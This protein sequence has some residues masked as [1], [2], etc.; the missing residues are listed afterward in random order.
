MARRN[1]L[2]EDLTE[3][4][5]LD[6]AAGN[7]RVLK[8]ITDADPRVRLH[9]LLYSK[10]E[11]RQQIEEMGV[12]V[13][14]ESQIARARKHAESQVTPLLKRIDELEKKIGDGQ[15][16]REASDFDASLKRFAN[17]FPITKPT[18]MRTADTTSGRSQE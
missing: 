9:E 7:P 17:E 5:I 16:A 18:S 6:L 3:Q 2:P 14:P 10:P 15:T 4:D 8:A 11:F 13:A 1:D 12:A